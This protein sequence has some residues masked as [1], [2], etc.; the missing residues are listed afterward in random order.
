MPT[1]TTAKLICL[2]NTFIPFFMVQLHS[3]TLT[4]FFHYTTL[5]ITIEALI[6]LDV[7][8]SAGINKISPRILHSRASALCEPF[9]HLFSQSLCH[10]TLLSCWKIHKIVPIFKA[11]D[12][13]SV[14]NYRPISLLLIMSKVLERLIFN[15]I[16]THISTYY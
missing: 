2:I 9:H 4:I 10:A 7:E 16:I 3:L 14:K 15:K 1:L 12:S 5:Y 11:G 13:N 8:K 6:S